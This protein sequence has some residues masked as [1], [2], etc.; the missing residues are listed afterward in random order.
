MPPQLWQREERDERNGDLF[1]AEQREANLAAF[2]ELLAKEGGAEAFFETVGEQQ[3][4]AGLKARGGQIIDATF[5]TVP[6]TDLVK[7]GKET[8]KDCQ[9]PEHWSDKQAALK[10][11]DARWTKKHDR[12]CY[13]TYWDF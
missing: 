9:V 8:V 7:D 4:A 11:T 5:I 3:A 13:G 12:C 10:D 1:L 2:K 6:K